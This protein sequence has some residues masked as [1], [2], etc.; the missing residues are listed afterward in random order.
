MGDQN[1][2]DGGNRGQSRSIGRRPGDESSERPLYK[3][4]ALLLVTF[5]SHEQERLTNLRHT[6]AF[7]VRYFFD[8]FLQARSDAE[9]QACIFFHLQNLSTGAPSGSLEFELTQ[10]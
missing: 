1:I 10:N 4:A 9:G 7:S 5:G 8:I 2:F 3:F 6:V